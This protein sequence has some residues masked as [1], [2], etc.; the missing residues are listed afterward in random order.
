MPRLPTVVAKS[1][2]TR[3]SAAL[4]SMIQVNH[5]N[6]PPCVESGPYTMAGQSVSLA[7]QASVSGINSAPESDASVWAGVP[8]KP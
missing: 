7:Y 2:A 1:E 4:P 5:E 8:A 6:G 3:Q